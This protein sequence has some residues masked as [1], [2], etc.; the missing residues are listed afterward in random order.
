MNIDEE[1]QII[2][3][4]DSP[5]P[6]VVPLRRVPSAD[7]MQTYSDHLAKGIIQPASRKLL[8]SSA[9]FVQE[10]VPPD[11]L[12]EDILQRRFIYSITART[13]GG[14]TAICL[15]IAASIA[16]GRPIGKFGVGRGRVLYLA[17]ENPDDVRMRWI[18]MSQQMGFD[19]AIDVHFIEGR[20][21]I[22]QMES[23]IRQ[24]AS[25]VGEFVLVVVD[26]SAAYF[27]GKDENDNKQ[28][29]DHARMLRGLIDAIPGGPTVLVCCHP[30]K[31]CGDDNLLPRG[32]GAFL[33]EVDGNLTC[34]KSGNI[35]ELHWQ[36]KFRGCEFAPLAFELKT[37]TH[38]R[39]KT[40]KG[41]LI[42]TV[43]A[44]HL[45]DEGQQA[46]AAVARSNE[47]QILE[48]LAGQPGA[49]IAEIAKG[50]GWYTA[51]G[52]P[53]KS[54]VHAAVGNLKK[55]RLVDSGRAG[56]ALTERGR[57][58]LGKGRSESRSEARTARTGKEAS[59]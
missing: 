51:S 21:S 23:R 38:E 29:G 43:V 16:G 41:R 42:P 4:A 18:A 39:L 34:T 53:Q 30:P 48:F 1:R 32:G 11:Y 10:F 7:E 56:L 19:A 37:K 26:T 12:I 46:L 6:N 28:L 13:G 59:E 50:L 3:S 8:Q 14:K 22:S 40:S 47:D 2:A 27:E 54:K 5:Q 33:A 17:G 24:E 55:Q 52:D 36:G 31:N 25:E 9:E 15:L 58:E 57:M 49:S 20:F 45:T 35:V 44:F